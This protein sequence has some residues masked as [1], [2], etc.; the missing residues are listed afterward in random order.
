[1]NMYLRYVALAA[2]TVTLAF[3]GVETALAG[4]KHSHYKHGHG[5][6]HTTKPYYSGRHHRRYDSDDDEKLIYGLLV[7][8]LFGYVIGNA[9]QP[10]PVQQSIYTPPA[11]T[12]YSPGA[13]VNT[14][15]QEREYQMKVI[16]GGR[17]ADA[18][19]TA[20]LQPDGS[21]YRG[22]AQVVSR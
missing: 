1:M 15:L 19:G 2:V 21:W 16:V 4:G 3:A 10:E 13:S 14:C 6:H 18:Y 7:G 17:E 12:H 8:G 9:N 5:Y 20:C 11:S 22:P